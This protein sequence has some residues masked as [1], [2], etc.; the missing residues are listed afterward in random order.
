MKKKLFIILGIL[1]LISLT[2]IIFNNSDKSENLDEFYSRKIEETEKKEEEKLI[3]KEEALKKY[4]EEVE[5]DRRLMEDN[6]EVLS[7]IKTSIETNT[8]CVSS[9]YI[10]YEKIDTL[11]EELR[12]TNDR[13]FNLT[14]HFDFIINPEKFK[15]E[16][17]KSKPEATEEEVEK[18]YNTV[19]NYNPNF[20]EEE[21]IYINESGDKCIKIKDIRRL[22]NNDG[23][24]KYFN[25]EYQIYEHEIPLVYNDILYSKN[26]HVK[27]VYIDS[28][29][30]YLDTD[31]Q[32]VENTLKYTCYTDAMDI[33]V[34]YNYKDK[35]IIYYNVDYRTWN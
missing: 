2:L 10:G 11:L 3:S 27:G 21:T 7:Q 31:G 15:E 16:V 35:E 12:K 5:R 29:S 33:S 25:G 9:N 22:H 18:I 23:I 8:N 30:V 1:V 34:V 13:E 26:E 32:E 17:R 24:V 14:K 19:L 4:Q 20:V 6:K 28:T